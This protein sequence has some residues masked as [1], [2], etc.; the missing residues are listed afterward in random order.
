MSY[1][2]SRRDINSI[3]EYASKLKDKSLRQICGDDVINNGY[4]GKGNFGQILEKYYFE[5]E[6]N[7]VSEPDFNE[8]G[9][10]LKSSPLKKS[11]KNHLSAKERLVL[12][13]IN[14][15]DI[16]NQDFETSSFLIK[17]NHLLL[18]LYLYESGVEVIDF[19]IKLV[20][21]WKIPQDDLAIIKSD[22]E[23]I[24]NKVKEGRAH[25]LSEG[26]TLYLGACTKGGKGGNPRQQPHST[27]LAKQRA[28]SLKQGYLNHVIGKLSLR[29][30]VNYGKVIDIQ[31]A[32]LNF[33]DLVIAKFE[34]YYTKSTEEI[35]ANLGLNLNKKAKSYFASL[36]KK[37]LG[38]DIKS[39]IEEFAKADIIIK[40]VRLN[41]NELPKESISFPTFKFEEIIN[42]EWDDS[43]FKDV[44][45][46]K[47]LFVFYKFKEKKLILEKVKFWN[48]PFS[49]IE[50]AKQV[51]EK[52]RQIV[53]NGNIVK[54]ILEN[55]TRKTNFPNNSFNSIAHVRPHAQNSE[56]TFPLPVID[57]ISGLNKFTKQCFWLNKTYIRDEIFNN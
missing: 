49:D 30:G 47:F 9:I 44:L 21:D 29:S 20:G 28:F 12:S 4:T 39:E 56:D 24:Q 22:W 1:S 27:I 51:W 32:D 43:S 16:I 15:N 6:P 42:E 53:S 34:K 37:I 10:E 57:K 52:T 50:K 36:S 7:S 13:I 31:A 55:G 18:I 45:E 11:K 8:V 35:E 17:N 48:M 46:H 41:E 25:E 19:V 54:G 33:E 2:Y 5:Y 14:Y 38:V 23:K 3:L 26:D 40:S